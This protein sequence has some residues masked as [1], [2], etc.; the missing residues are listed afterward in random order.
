V[1]DLG[2]LEEAQAAVHAVR[3][4]ALNSAVS[5]TRLCALLR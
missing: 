5:I 1:L 2:P 3:H 4:A